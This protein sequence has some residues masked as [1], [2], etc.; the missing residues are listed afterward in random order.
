MT[1]AGE[2]TVWL[3]D[4]NEHELRTHRALLEKTL[5]PNV[6][7]DAILA[8]ARLHD[9]SDVMSNRDTACIIIDERLKE[10]GVANY[11][12]IELANYLRGINTKIPIY[13][14][15]NYAE[16]ID[17]FADCQWTVEDIISKS[18]M[19]VEKQ[20][21]AVVARIL[22]RIDVYQDIIEVRQQ[23][24]RSLLKKSLN[25]ELTV[26]EESE[27]GELQLERSSAILA[28]ELLVLRQV[29]EV[30]RAHERLM[31]LLE[32]RPNKDGQDAK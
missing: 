15:T 17:E 24:F 22:R 31:E 12:G 11:Q 4:D 23:R 28:D 16:E 21:K 25:S 9:Y 10:T 2:P 19:T 13:I 5:P 8:R 26:D 7:V 20:K 29:N 18:D 3:I 30:I 32:R 6:R 1:T 14:L 27:L